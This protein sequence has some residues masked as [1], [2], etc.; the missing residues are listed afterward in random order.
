MAAR[1]MREKLTCECGGGEV[2]VCLGSWEDE[3]EIQDNPGV[4][5]RGM[6]SQLSGGSR[7]VYKRKDWRGLASVQGVVCVVFVCVVFWVLSRK[8]EIVRITTG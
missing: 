4:P 8:K 7:G 5:Q 6:F 2:S 3:P 1:V